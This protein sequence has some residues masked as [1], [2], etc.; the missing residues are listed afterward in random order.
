M[1]DTPLV[2]V[3]II[4]LN[5]GEFIA[6]AIESVFAQTYRDWELLLVDDGSTDASAE[7]ALRY[8]REHPERVRYLQH[9]G[10]ENRGMSASRNLGINSARGRLIAFLDSD[11]VWTAD[12]LDEQV[13]ILSSQPRASMVYG[14]IQLWYSW[15]GKPED[16]R[17]DFIPELNVQPDRLVHPPELLTALLRNESVTATNGLI[18]REIIES[19]GGYEESFRGMYEDQVFY[20]KICLKAPVFVSSKCWYRWRKHPASA[21][22]VALSKG[23]Y[24]PARLKF[25]IWLKEYLSE[26]GIKDSEIRKALNEETFKCRYPALFNRYRHIRH[27]SLVMKERLKSLARRA[28]PG[29]VYGGLRALSRGQSYRPPRARERMRVLVISSAFPPMQAGEADHTLHLCEHLAARG[30]DVH[31]LTTRREAGPGA[32]SFEIYPLMRSWSWRD[33]PRLALRLRRSAPDA[34]L[35]FYI[36]WIYDYQPM[37]TFA[38]TIS[39]ALIPR[40]PFITEFANAIG[41]KPE[42]FSR[43]AR[44]I[45]KAVGMWAG[46]RGSDYRYGTLLRD[47]DRII[48][49]SDLHRATLSQH[50]P[51]VD[52]KSVLITPPPILLIRPED[53]G[54]A[55]KEGRDAL[56][57]TDE[58]FLIAYLG[59]IYPGKGIETLLK[60]L[61]SV[62]R[63]RSN[64]RLVVV[65]GTLQG[66]SSYAEEVC[67]LPEQMGIDDKVI[68]AGGF[69]WDSDKASTNLRAADA[70]VL[71]IEIGVQ[72]NNSSFAAAAAHGLPIIATRGTDL[73]RQFIHQENIYLCPPKDPEAMAS[74][75][76]L[77]MDA[78]DLRASL[79]AGALRLAQA[80]F[81]WD[82]VVERT[83]A[84]LDECKK[85]DR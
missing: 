48:I 33:L 83:L 32:Q 49:L 68:W 73:E 43:V 35:L 59:Y 39:K 78:P 54:A 5:T 2:S 53:N 28:L 6:E 36:G 40:A 29:S 27:R 15:T 1:S 66:F 74:A 34:V 37:I 70:F 56:G 47:S 16:A 76:K 41:A 17:R 11:D 51:G 82:G 14:A 52:N 69:S 31:L 64:A 61:Q 19:V 25:L 21:C 23:E 84:L 63:E 75:I 58:D 45:R 8:S 65:G 10:H 80:W 30:L 85:P 4:F 77:L 38:A 50:F 42:Q 46:A 62:A 55:R 12:K 81:S 67:R 18:R 72:M 20:S 7:I 44:G 57:L 79:G 3:I 26:Q 9:P 71:P 22:A 13:A 60:A 24:E